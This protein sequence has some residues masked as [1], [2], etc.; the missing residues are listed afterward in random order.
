M[1]DENFER[2]NKKGYGLG[3]KQASKLSF[4]VAVPGA[5]D[6]AQEY[7]FQTFKCF[8]KLVEAV[9]IGFYNS[10]CRHLY[11]LLEFSYGMKLTSKV[12]QEGKTKEKTAP[13]FL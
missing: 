2:F 6:G 13:T 8:W 7:C 9:M 1:Q 12:M 11:G 10:N 4:Q 5:V 3:L